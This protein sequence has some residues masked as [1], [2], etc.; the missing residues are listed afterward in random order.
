MVTMTLSTRSASVKIRYLMKDISKL[1]SVEEEQKWDMGKDYKELRRL[2]EVN[3]CD[4]VLFFR[5]TKRADDVWMGI[6]DGMSVLFRMYNVSTV[7]DCNFPVNGFKECGHVV[8]FTQ[9]FEEVEHLR[10]VK[11]VIEE[12]FRSPEVKDK[13]LCFF[14]VD[15]MIWVRCYRI[16]EKL[17][18]MGP[19]MVLEVVGVFERCFGGEVLY[20]IERDSGEEK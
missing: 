7:R 6:R 2:M 9:E 19:R 1:I 8:M 14:Y 10:H 18:E 5:S 4:T 16:G 15:G 17:E 3:E 12:I 11:G 13:A 20:K